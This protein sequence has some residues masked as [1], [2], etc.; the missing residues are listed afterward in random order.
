MNFRRGTGLSGLSINWG[1]WADVGVA[2]ERNLAAKL[3][4]KGIISFSPEIGI[5][6]LRTLLVQAPSGSVTVL[7]SN[8]DTYLVL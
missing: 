8:W 2:A 3:Q 1:A 5:E 7:K 4:K 6:A